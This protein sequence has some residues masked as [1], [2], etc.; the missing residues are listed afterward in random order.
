MRGGGRVWMGRGWG[1]GEGGQEGDGGMEGKR[2][3]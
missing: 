1:I 2:E 3:E